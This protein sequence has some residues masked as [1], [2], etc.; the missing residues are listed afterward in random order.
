M[1]EM[2][3]W[4]LRRCVST[5]RGGMVTKGLGNTLNSL[6]GHDGE[7]FPEPP[8]RKIVTAAG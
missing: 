6:T 7:I 5:G 1:K 3:A 8:L 2:A 4:V